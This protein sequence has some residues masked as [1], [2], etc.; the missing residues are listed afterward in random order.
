MLQQPSMGYGV[1]APEIGYL[2]GQYKRIENHVAQ[3]GRGILWGGL[4]LYPEAVGHGI[5]HFAN[6]LLKDKG[7]SLQ[8]KRCLITGSG[9]VALNVAQK[10][11]DF[12]AIPL[13]FTD[14]GGH[15]LEPEGLQQLLTTSTNQ[16]RYD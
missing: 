16:H 14:S 9:K 3:R 7:D 15:I 2:Y 6:E 5:V 8:G 13:S 12:G 11:L 1:G 10:L 4:Q